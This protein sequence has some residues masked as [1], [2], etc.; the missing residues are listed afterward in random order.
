MKVKLKFTNHT[1]SKEHTLKIGEAIAIGRSSKCDFQLDDERMSSKHCRFNLSHDRLEIV[2]LDSK[3]GTYLN[4]IRVENSQVFTGDRIRVGTTIITL[5]EPD[6]DTEAERVLTF[7]G[8]T[9]DRINYELKADFT[10]AR[11]DNQSAEKNLKIN[12]YASQ[13]KEVAARKQVQSKIR[14]SK[15]EIRKNNKALSVVAAILDFVAIIGVLILPV[16]IISRS[17]PDQKEKNTILLASEVLILALFFLWN[18][19]I[20]RFTF[21]E[22]LSGIKSKYQNQ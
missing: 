18:F 21:G 22:S 3:N 20:A 1:G 14:L 12:P 10:G 16:M 9:K 8:A 2:D 13:M 5:D 17:L 11:G 15:Q 6:L 4:G 7:P 19:K